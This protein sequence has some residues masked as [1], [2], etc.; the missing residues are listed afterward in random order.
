M[1]IDS[2]IGIV[3]IL[4]MLIAL[5]AGVFAIGAW[6]DRGTSGS[7]TVMTPLAPT[8]VLDTLSRHFVR[9]S[10]SVQH[11][12]SGFVSLLSPP[13]MGTG[14][15]LLLL[16]WPIG[17]IYLLTDAGRGRLHATARR[18]VTDTEVEME[19]E[20]T[21]VREQIEHFAR[22]LERGADD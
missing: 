16:L 20:N 12:D 18:S 1:D 11:R 17:L 4:A 5:V 7:V 19:W 15:L 3:I 10:W 9:Q 2:L 22:W 8:E 13:N 14:C 21:R 6:L